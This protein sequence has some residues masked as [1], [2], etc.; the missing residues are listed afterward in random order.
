MDFSK[1][2]IIDSLST[3]LSVGAEREG[4]AIG[5]FE[6][7]PT[8]RTLRHHYQHVLSLLVLFDEVLVSTSPV[9]RREI[10]LLEDAGII[11]RVE[12]REPRGGPEPL[13]SDRRYGG[14]PPAR[15]LK[16]LALI[17]EYQPIV[18]EYLMRHGFPYDL[19]FARGFGIS[20]RRYYEEFLEY[21]IAY[22]QGDKTRLQNTSF[23]ARMPRKGLNLISR[24]LFRFGTGAQNPFNT[25]LIMAIHCA[26]VLQSSQELSVEFG[27]GVASKEFRAISNRTGLVRLGSS[28]A[29]AESF[30]VVQSVIREDQPYFPQIETLHDVIRLRKDPRLESFRRKLADFHSSVA[31]GDVK[32]ATRF[33]ADVR[34][35]CQS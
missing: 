4:L 22:A 18:V 15:L 13:V 17:Q 21:A 24:R 14:T 33:R 31:A 10:P 7:W 3:A 5:A 32:A 6:G 30:S 29:V 8:M 11:R 16:S 23:V 9:E 35:V 2:L 12:K 34:K 27:V 26:N 25:I 19:E 28:S 20:R 1:V